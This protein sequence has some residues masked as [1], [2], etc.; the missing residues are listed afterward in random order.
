MHI[1]RYCAPLQNPDLVQYDS[2]KKKKKTFEMF[3]YSAL[4]LYNFAV[5]EFSTKVLF[6]FLTVLM[7][8]R[9][10]QMLR[11][12][13]S[14]PPGPWGLPVLGSLPFL[15]GDLHLHFRDL[16][17]K[18]GSLISTRL[19]S[20]LIVVLSDYKMI[21]D[22]FRKEEFTGRP[23]TEFTNILGGYGESLFYRLARC[24]K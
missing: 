13:T 18:Y 23:T 6:V 8:V 4:V 21:R 1:N 3:V 5:E 12:A 15:K 22:A 7:L 10:L 9:G 14:L 2:L 17:H 11:E 24:Y 20:Q 16:T 19:G